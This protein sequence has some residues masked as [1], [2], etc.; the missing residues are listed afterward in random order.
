MT[1][2]GDPPT[3]DRHPRDVTAGILG[4]LVGIGAVILT[5]ETKLTA[6]KALLGGVYIK[7]EYRNALMIAG[8][9]LIALAAILILVSTSALSDQS[10]T[11][12]LRR[13][14]VFLGCA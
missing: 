3:S 12:V 4:L 6:T 14:V 7:D 11:G 5:S 1:V 10:T 8:Y 9:A 13:F 2:N